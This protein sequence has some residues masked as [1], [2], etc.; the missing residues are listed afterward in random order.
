MKVCSFRDSLHHPNVQPDVIL[1]GSP[2]AEVQSLQLSSP[3]SGH[4]SRCSLQNVQ[5]KPQQ[6]NN[7][8]L[9]NGKLGYL[10]IGCSGY[11]IQ[12]MIIQF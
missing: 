11:K 9:V 8:K 1:H 6:I 4:I 12:P 3:Q 7:I 10:V 2:D 5:K